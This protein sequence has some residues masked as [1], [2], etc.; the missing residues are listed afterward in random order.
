MTKRLYFIIGMVT[1][2]IL[3]WLFIAS[4]LQDCADMQDDSDDNTVFEDPE[5]RI[6]S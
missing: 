2:A 6:V 1:G 5:L 4:A 3:L